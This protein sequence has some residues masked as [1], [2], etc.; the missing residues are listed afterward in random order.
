MFIGGRQRNALIVNWIRLKLAANCSL[1]TIIIMSSA[2]NEC[3]P[4]NG[5]KTFLNWCELIFEFRERIFCEPFGLMEL[6]ME[7][8]KRSISGYCIYI[9]CFDRIKAHAFAQFGRIK[10]PR[11]KLKT[12]EIFLESI[13]FALNF[14][15]LLGM[16]TN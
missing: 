12:E 14:E 6:A 5:E 16:R 9:C 10:K 15:R 13:F 4:T 7:H 2:V 11:T 1:R 8:L 3:Q